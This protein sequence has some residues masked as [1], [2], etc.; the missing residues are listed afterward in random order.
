MM[1]KLVIVKL[2]YRL[3]L[4]YSLLC[5]HQVAS[6]RKVRISFLCNCTLQRYTG[7]LG[8]KH[9][10]VFSIFSIH[11]SL[12]RRGIH[13]VSYLGVCPFYMRFLCANLD[14]EGFWG[15]SFCAILVPTK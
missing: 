7:R 3:M 2:T 11:F 13:S 10:S 1:V 14:R 15:L 6:F 9:S 4:R 5:N 8:L 12:M